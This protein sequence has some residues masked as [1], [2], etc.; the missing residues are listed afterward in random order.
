MLSVD[1][2]TTDRP[3]NT[4]GSR[5]GAHLLA[6]GLV[7]AVTCYLILGVL[8]TRLLPS[9]SL[10][11]WPLGNVVAAMISL[12]APVAVAAFLVHRQR[13]Q[14]VGMQILSHVGAATAVLF[15]CLVPFGA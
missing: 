14:S 8:V 1:T 5:W 4:T 6:I 2:T 3:K 9:E 13:G 11:P 7:W 15:L 12:Y 10:D